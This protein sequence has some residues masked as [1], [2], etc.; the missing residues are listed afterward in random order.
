MQWCLCICKDQHYCR[1]SKNLF[2][3]WSIFWPYRISVITAF[4]FVIHLTPCILDCVYLIALRAY[5]YHG[6]M[7]YLGEVLCC[8][9]A[10]VWC[11]ASESHWPQTWFITRL[12]S[13]AEVLHSHNLSLTAGELHPLKPSVLGMGIIPFGS[14]RYHCICRRQRECVKITLGCLF[15]CWCFAVNCL[16]LVWAWIWLGSFPQLWIC[17]FFILLQPYVI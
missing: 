6:K 11:W 1:K 14:A 4:F 7:L 2:T 17:P 15:E 13:S 12:G 9:S 3:F 16:H 10:G 8:W 5:Y